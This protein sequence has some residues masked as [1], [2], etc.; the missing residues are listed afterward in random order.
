MAKKNPKNIKVE[1]PKKAQKPNLTAP[2][3]R[4]LRPGA[5]ESFRLQ[6]RLPRSGPKL[7]GAFRILFD[8][9]KLLCKNWKLF[10]G[11][12]LIYLLLE[13]ILV[14]GLS[15]VTSG[16]SLGQTKH[17]LSSATNAATTATSLFLLLV[18]TGTGNSSSTAYQF[19]LLLFISLVLIWSIRQHYLGVAIRIRDGFYKGI[20]PFVP[21]FLVLLTIGLELIPA[22]AGIV[23]YSA[24][25]SNGIA[26]T[27]AERILWVCLTLI[28]VLVSCYYIS[29]SI[30][31][32]YIVT[33]QDMTPL[34]ALK[35]ASKLVRGR[36]LRVMQRIIFLPIAV[37]II[38]AI[39]IVPFLL[40]A[41]KVAPVAFFVVTAVMVAV[42]HAYLYGLYRELLNEQTE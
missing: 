11:I 14:Q 42:L 41:V 26:A 12:L 23:L 13:L 31:A 21:F 1:T 4:R 2:T 9:V 33:L 6:K 27:A 3:P 7:A 8:S 15:L 17:L 16:S 29:G 39:L 25:T 36:R 38:M 5:Y 37:F 35:M 22:A 20:A 32:L 30:F 19:I 28:L 18:G 40:F 24:V 34:R 10:G